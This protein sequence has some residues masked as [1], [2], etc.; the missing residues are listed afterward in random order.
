MGGR[1]IFN[2]AGFFSKYKDLQLQT[3]SVSPT[4]GG[5]ILTVDNAGSVDLYGF[6]AEIVARPVAGLDINAGIG[7]LHN[8]YKS[9][10]AG[11]GY[12]INN[13]L[14]KAPEWTISLG[15]QYAARLPGDSGT[16]TLRGDMNYRSKTYHDPANS[17]SI[18]QPGYALVDA[19]LSWNTGDDR[20]EFALFGKNLTNKFYF[21]AAEFVPSF[22]FRNMVLGRPREWGVSATARF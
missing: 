21:T 2:L 17:V 15:A 7:Y 5:L 19:R 22:G 6:E 12:S 1:L 4:T 10:A 13:V 8:E 18:V 16:L 14:P 20:F 3:N 9:L 11:T